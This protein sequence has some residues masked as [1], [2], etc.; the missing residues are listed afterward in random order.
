MATSNVK[1]NF[2]QSNHKLT[3]FRHERTKNIPLDCAKSIVKVTKKKFTNFLP[4]CEGKVVKPK[5]VAALPYEPTLSHWLLCQQWIINKLLILCGGKYNFLSKNLNIKSS[6]TCLF[7]D[8]VQIY[9]EKA[10]GWGDWDINKTK[11]PLKEQLDVGNNKWQ[12]NFGRIQRNANCIFLYARKIED[13]LFLW[14]ANGVFSIIFNASWT[15]VKRNW[16]Q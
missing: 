3:Y 9:H 5:L 12:R 8:T 4:I 11:W 15:N 7:Y 13:F 2:N 16:R 10:K 14:V 1:E 6:A